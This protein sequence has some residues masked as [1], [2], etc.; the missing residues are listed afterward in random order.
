MLENFGLFAINESGDT[1]MHIFCADIFG[2]QTL[3]G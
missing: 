2:L 1:E 3:K